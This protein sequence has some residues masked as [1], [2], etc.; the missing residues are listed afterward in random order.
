MYCLISTFNKTFDELGLIYFIP[1]F[2][3]L[4]IKTG[5]IVEIPI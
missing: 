2:L 1:S 4:E 3:E 5:Q